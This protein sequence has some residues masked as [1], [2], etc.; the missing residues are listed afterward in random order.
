MVEALRGVARRHE[1]AQ[2]QLISKFSNLLAA[3]RGVANHFVASL[4]AMT[5]V[6]AA[7]QAAPSQPADRQ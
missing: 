2:T 1:M 4:L 7:D 6:R 5:K 3:W